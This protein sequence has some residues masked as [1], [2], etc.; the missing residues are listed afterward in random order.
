[1]RERRSLV[2]DDDAHNRRI[3]LDFQPAN[4]G[5]DVLFDL[6]QRRGDR[7]E[8][9]RPLLGLARRLGALVYPVEQLAPNFRGAFLVFVEVEGEFPQPSRI[10]GLPDFRLERRDLDLPAFPLR[11]GPHDV[12]CEALRRL[13]TSQAFP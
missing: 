1:M 11:R 7:P 4:P 9:I 5:V 12:R 8:R 6:M 10:G 13:E 3:V 2:R